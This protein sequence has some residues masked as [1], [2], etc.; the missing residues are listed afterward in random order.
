MQPVFDFV[1]KNC[2]QSPLSNKDS[3]TATSLKNE[4]LLLSRAFDILI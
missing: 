2:S 1:N 4:D 3:E